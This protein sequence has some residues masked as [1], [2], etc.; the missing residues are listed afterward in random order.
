MPT[1]LLE[2]VPSDLYECLQRRAASQRRSLPEETLLLLREALRQ[3]DPA[4]PPLEYVPL[5]EL[6]APYDLPLP[7][8]GVEVQALP[9]EPPPL[10][11]ILRRERSP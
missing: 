5:E 3:G 10:D 8:Q 4:S 2:N 1:L 7:G 6:C 9:G 11:L